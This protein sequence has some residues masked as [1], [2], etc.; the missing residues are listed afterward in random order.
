M[1]L[2]I[3]DS[4]RKYPELSLETKTAYGEAPELVVKQHKAFGAIKSVLLAMMEQDLKNTGQCR[5][6]LAN[7]PWGVHLSAFGLPKSS[8]IILIFNHE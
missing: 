5:L 4:L 6:Y 3:A 8:P 1:L 7:K 2:K